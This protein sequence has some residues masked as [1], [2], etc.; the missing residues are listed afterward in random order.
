MKGVIKTLKNN[1]FNKILKI[2]NNLKEIK[3]FIIGKLF[4]LFILFL[5]EKI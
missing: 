4:N 3:H 2:L 5:K 1:Y